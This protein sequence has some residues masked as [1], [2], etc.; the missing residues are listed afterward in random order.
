MIEYPDLIKTKYIYVYNK[1]L[2]KRKRIDYE[3]R[4]TR[5]Y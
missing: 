1:I 4:K 2:R 3:S 5:P